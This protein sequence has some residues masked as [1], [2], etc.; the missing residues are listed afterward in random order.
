MTKYIALLRGISPGFPNMSGAH[1]RGVFED[2]GFK[3]VKSIIGSGNVVFETNEGDK[4]KLE[5]I[6]EQ[7]FPRKLGFTS[8]TIIRT[9]KNMEDL[10]AKD[11]FKGLTHSKE[12]SL[13]ITFTKRNI[14]KGVEIP[15][16]E[17]W[18]IAETYPDA[19]ASVTDLSQKKTPNTMVEL[20]KRL[21][22][23]ITTRT[24]KTVEK[25]VKAFA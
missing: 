14:P 11:P 23:D 21:G 7:A 15:D 16:G 25:I 3:N 13:N 6:I 5:T 24:W 22:K 12:L 9:Q 20:E 1:L 4:A 18:H 10:L 8:T 2:L 19:V 17:G